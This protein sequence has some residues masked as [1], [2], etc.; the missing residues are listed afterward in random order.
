MSHLF[1]PRASQSSILQYTG[2][3]LGISA[4]PGSGKTQMLS[5]LAAHILS[6]GRLEPDQEVLVVTLVNSAVDNFTSRIADFIQTGSLIPHLGY[7]VRTLH[8]LAHDIV[9]EDPS[10]VGLEQDFAIMDETGSLNMIRSSADA[11]VREHPYF[12]ENYVSPALEDQ[13]RRRTANR[14][15][16][17]YVESIAA[18]FIR[19]AKDRHLAPE[20][21]RTQL[22]ASGEPLP[23][24]EMGFEIYA[25]YQ[26]SLGY[27]GAVD[28]DDLVRLAF[29]ALQSSPEL[30]QRLQ[31]RW[32]FVLEDEAQGGAAFPA[33]LVPDLAGIRPKLQGPT[34]G[35]RDFVI[36]EESDRGLPG[37]IN[38]IGIESPGLTASPAI[39]KYVRSLMGEA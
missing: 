3:R 13:Q 20:D 32:P 9:R 21:L 34:E 23:L 12:F 10:L 7:R 22:E 8:G 39:A 5:A 27:R 6:T 17:D 1:S 38:L 11:W 14:D 19:S 29:Q 18:S 16:P 26:R 36:R 2:G 37:I 28:F 33:D 15:W 30:L 31:H 4:V 25:D 24:A 35:F